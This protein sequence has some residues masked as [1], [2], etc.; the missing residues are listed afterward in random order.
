MTPIISAM[1]LKIVLARTVP[2]TQLNSGRN[3]G[4]AP[5]RDESRTHGPAGGRTARTRGS[6]T[7]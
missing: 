6:N 7:A 5:F 1:T 4:S 3:M 2:T